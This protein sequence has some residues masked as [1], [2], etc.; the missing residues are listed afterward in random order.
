VA[1]AVREPLSGELLR[2]EWKRSPYRRNG[3]MLKFGKYIE[4]AITTDVCDDGSIWQYCI[5]TIGRMAAPASLPERRRAA[6][7]FAIQQ[8]ERMAANLR[9]YIATEPDTHDRPQNDLSYEQPEP[10]NEVTL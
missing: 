10:G 8:L 4:L 9:A 5:A 3:E 2:P 1:E 7:E 6:V